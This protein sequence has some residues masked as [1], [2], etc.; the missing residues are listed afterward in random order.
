MH[1]VNFDHGVFLK[2]YDNGV[3]KMEKKDE[4][5]EYGGGSFFVM[6]HPKMSVREKI[7]KTLMDFDLK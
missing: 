5:C 7:I 4:V 2:R 1:D 6:N 3:K